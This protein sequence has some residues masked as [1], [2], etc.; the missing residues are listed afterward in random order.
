MSVL[1]G[2]SDDIMKQ[3]NKIIF[4][5]IWNN[6]PDKIKRNIMKLP[7][8]LGGLS[9]PDIYIK[10]KSLKIAWVPKALGQINSWNYWIYQYFP[11]AFGTFWHC[12]INSKDINILTEGIQNQLVKEIITYWFEY[13]FHIPKTIHDIQNQIVWYNSHIKVGGE[14]IF[15]RQLYDKNIL[16]VNNV[17]HP[18]GELMKFDEF[19]AKYNLNFNYLTYLGILSAFPKNWKRCIANIQIEN[20][21]IQRYE[22]LI[23]LTKKKKKF[24]NMFTM[25]LL[26]NYIMTHLLQAIEDGM[27]ISMVNL[28]K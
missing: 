22:P 9:V 6:K 27:H 18:N 15:N 14:M 26:I 11:L 5:F 16:Y 21:E 1:P 23:V 2:P 3:I 25:I 24:V 4:E 17:S 12:N 13:T 28:H 20:E 7:K 8:L 10:N 19:C